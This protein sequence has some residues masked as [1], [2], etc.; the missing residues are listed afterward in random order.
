M[1][2]DISNIR[3]RS[4]AR[5]DC[6]AISS[7]FTNQGWDKPVTQYKHYLALQNSGER[8]VI[9]AQVDG[10]FAGYLTILWTSEYGPFHQAG[11][12]EIVDFNVL[13]RFQRRGIGSSLMDEAERRIAQHSHVAGIGVGLIKDYGP[14]QVLY[15]KRGYIPDGT[16]ASYDSRPLAYHTT[17][18]A[19]D[20][21]ILHM[22]KNLR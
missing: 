22:T 5:E 18:T 21:L 15:A 14:A 9:L 10:E 11:I 8:D 12:P 6:E 16:G 13:K 19:G 4:I 17:L 20:D 7:A 2:E 1:D 3:L